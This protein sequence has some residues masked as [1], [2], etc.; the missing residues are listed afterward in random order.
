[1]SASNR[2][3][4]LIALIGAIFYLP[5]LGGV[6]LFDWDEINFA[7]IAREMVVLGDYL[8]IHVQFIPFTEKPPLF[9]WFQALSMEAFGI[10]EYGARFP[11]AVCGIVTLV[12]LYK[13]G[14]RLRDARFG[15]LW[16]GA[17]FGSVLPHL[18]FKSG[19]IDPWFNLFIFLGIYNLILVY[20][21]KEGMPGMTLSASKWRYLLWAGVFTGLAILTKGPVAY[22]ITGL[23]LGVYWILKRF[24]FYINPL[25]VVVYTITALGV[26]GLW[27]GVETLVHGPQF[28]VEFTVRQWEIFSRPDAGHVGFPGYHFVVVL[29]GC[30][31]ASIFLIRSHFSLPLE[32]EHERNFRKWMLI[33]FWVVLL[34]FTVVQSKIV[35]YSSMTY[36]PLT[37][38][39]A[40]VAEYLIQQKIAWKGWMKGMLL[41]IAILTGLVVIILPFAGMNIDILRPL[42]AQDPFALK[43]LDAVVPWTGVESIAGILLIGVVVAFVVL[44]NRQRSIRAFQVLFGGVGVFVFLT[45]IL[46]IKKIEAYSQRAA[47]DFYISKQDCNCYV[48][49]ERF[50]SYGHLF[51]KRLQ[52]GEDPRSLN[53]EWLKRGDIDK[54]AYFVAK[55][56]GTKELETIE[57]M[58][59]LYEENGF[60]FW[61]RAAKN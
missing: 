43:N 7:E 47:I 6:H 51:Y 16:A 41:G 20:W 48:V 39:T 35:H 19:I 11:N 34:L 14:E 2:N 29:I 33:L 30:F 61:K 37:F 46:F 9:F 55:V 21:R 24:R 3:A 50:R 58:E 5:F 59:F 31:P 49:P 53:K 8:R 32:S 18:Y 27:Y 13:L 45:L 15:W 22:L 17:Y 56:T 44:M 12:V 10:G 25:E 4:W 52:P 28:V 42:F 54:D 1:M 26:T 40:Q 36:F 57:D 23:T 38:L 60:T